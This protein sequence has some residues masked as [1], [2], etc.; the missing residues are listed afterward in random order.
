MQRLLTGS[1]IVLAVAGMLAAAAAI[2]FI[3]AAALSRAEPAPAVDDSATGAAAPA[4]ADGGAPGAAPDRDV[5]GRE[6]NP[7][8]QRSKRR[9]RIRW[10]D[11]SAVGLPHAGRLVRGVQLP[12]EGATFFTWDP[13][14][15][16]RPNRRWRRW[17]TDV[18]V[19]TVLDV[20][21]D[22]ARDNPGAPRIAVGDLSRPRGG[23]FGPQ[24]GSIGHASHQNGLDVDVYYPLRSGRERAPLEVS[25]ID[26]RLAQDL[27]DRFVAAGAVKVFVGPSTPLTG[28][29]GIVE[30]LVHHDNHL[31]VRLAP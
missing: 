14:E 23:D 24:F 10:R 9:Q 5:A 18:L 20:A 21:R 6:A 8:G 26:M 12:A 11:S 19:R 22:F 3:A 13:I 17:G 4:R 27:V 15:K 16:R 29:P 31:H 2:A 30:R 25:E 28:P 1:K 7:E